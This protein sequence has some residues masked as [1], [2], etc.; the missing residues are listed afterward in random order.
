MIHNIKRFFY[1]LF[2]NPKLL[3]DILW[4]KMGAFI[5][6]RLFLEVHFLNK[7]GYKL[8]LD[9]PK[10]FNEKLQWLKLNDRHP[11]YT[12]M[13]DKATAKDYVASVVGDK[14]IIPT[15]GVWNNVEDIEWGKLPNKFVVKSTG[16]SGGVVVCKDKNKFDIAAATSKLKKLGSRK[17]YNQNREYPYRDV[18]HRYIAEALLENGKDTDIPDYKI[19]CFN[20]VPYYIQVDVDRSVHHCRNIYDTNWNLQDL[21]IE[22]PNITDRIIEKPQNLETMLELAKMLSQ[23]KVHVRVDLYNIDG[24]IYFGELTFFHGSGIE[25]F[26]PIEWDYKFGELLHLPIDKE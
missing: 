3:F 15:Y 16:D 13:V 22:F 10:T 25:K 1:H 11:E 6:D 5:P 9:N 7:T 24:N 12:K 18:P 4:C 2:N 26:K 20:G 14:F 17:Y 21:Q 23:D 19:F 8:N